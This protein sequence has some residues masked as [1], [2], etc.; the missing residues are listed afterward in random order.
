ML[1]IVVKPGSVAIVYAVKFNVCQLSQS[2][3]PVLIR[4]KVDVV[5]LLMVFVF[6]SLV[7]MILILGQS[8]LILRL[9]EPI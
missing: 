4:E 6:G 3:E 2:Q 8:L 9:K 1:L 7:R 5:V